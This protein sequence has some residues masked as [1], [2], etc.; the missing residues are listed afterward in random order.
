[1]SE[2]IES[3]SHVEV[4]R[5]VEL[6]IL[7]TAVWLRNLGSLQ[8]LASNDARVFNLSFV[9][10]DGGIDQVV[11]EDET[12][13]LEFLLGGVLGEKVRELFKKS[14]Q[15]PMWCCEVLNSVTMEKMGMTDQDS[16]ISEDHVG[17]V[18]GS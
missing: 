9:N 11:G 14:N 16:F 7:G 15:M 3:G 12:A 2:Y 8:K 5:R 4:S 17:E 6:W 13:S 10:R 18:G 1:M